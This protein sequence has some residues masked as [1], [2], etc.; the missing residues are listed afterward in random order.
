[1]ADIV[2]VLDESASMMTCY[3]YYIECINSFI[4]TQKE[5]NPHGKFTMVKFNSDVTTLCVDSDIRSLPEFTTDYYK[6]DG[7]TALYDAIDHAI[8]LKYSENNKN[9]IM[10]IL[11]DGEDNNSKYTNKQTVVN[12][13][14]NMYQHGWDFVYI[15]SNQQTL[16]IG[17]RLGINN[18]VSYNETKNSIINVV[19]VCNI[20]VGHCIEKWTGQQNCFSHQS[21][22]EDVRDLMDTIEQLKF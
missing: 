14:Q 16:D 17:Q 7:V 6:P 15:A 13:I 5:F 9:V 18:C 11:T 4:Q 22:P 10:F 1:M 2:F 8:K 12:N 21:I 20:A 3:Q 19:N